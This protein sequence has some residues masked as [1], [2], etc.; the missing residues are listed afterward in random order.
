MASIKLYSKVFVYINGSLLTENADV[1]LTRHAGIAPVSTLFLGYA[2]PMQGSQF[3]EIEIGNAVP[4]AGFE[5]DPGLMESSGGP[6]N[7]TLAAANA[8][9]SSDGNILEDNLSYAINNETKLEI[10][11]HGEFANWIAN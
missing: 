4:N 7:I 2:G 8:T 5:F 10:R 3:I 6:V 9:L 1:K 11:F